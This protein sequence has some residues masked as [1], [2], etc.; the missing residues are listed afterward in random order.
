[1]CRQVP[2]YS[3]A[4]ASE[5]GRLFCKRSHGNSAEMNS[6]G[7]EY[8]EQAVSP[9]DLATMR[10]EAGQTTSCIR[11]LQLPV[12]IITTSRRV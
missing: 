8:S 4:M 2:L 11:G 5:N 7:D 3:V 10:Q 9:S 12:E 6:L 1:M